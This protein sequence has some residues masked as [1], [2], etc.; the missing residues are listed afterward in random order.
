MQYESLNEEQN[1]TLQITVMP[2]KLKN[3]E[4]WASKSFM[5]RK[6]KKMVQFQASYLEV[7]PTEL[8]YIC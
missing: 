7:L 8:K 6:P 3:N 5:I 2:S 4:A 1:Y